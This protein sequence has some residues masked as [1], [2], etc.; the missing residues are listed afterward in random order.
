[1]SDVGG[2]D[3][4]ADLQDYLNAKDINTLFIKI[5]NPIQFIV[6]CECVAMP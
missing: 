5:D 2:A 6:S 4:Q 3:I 1:M